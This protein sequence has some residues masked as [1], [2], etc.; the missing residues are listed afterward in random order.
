MDRVRLS[1]DIVEEVFIRLNVTS[2]KDLLRVILGE[3]TCAEDP[4]DE[5]HATQ[6]RAN[7]LEVRKKVRINE[8]R[9]HGVGARQSHAAAA[10]R[11]QSHR[12]DG[13]AVAQWKRERWRRALRGL[14]DELHIRLHERGL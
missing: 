5:A 8:R 4:A 3:R 10:A 12:A 1:A 2:G 9:R 7:I 13:K 14:E 6:Q 11:V